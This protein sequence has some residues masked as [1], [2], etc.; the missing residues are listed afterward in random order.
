MPV[1]VIDQIED[2][3]INAH[4]ETMKVETKGLNLTEYQLYAMVSR[5]Y[6]CGD[7][8]AIKARNGKT[9]KEAI[10]SYWKE[11]DIQYNVKENSK[12]Y[13]HDLYKNYMSEPKEGSGLSLVN[14]RKSEWLLFLTG[15]FDKIDEYYVESN[16]YSIEGINLYNTDGT[17]NEAEISKLEN[18]L[19]IKVNTISGQYM[20]NGLQYKQCTWWAYSRASEYLGKAYPKQ[21]NGTSGNGKD[22]YD[23]NRKNGWFDYGSEPRANS[24]VCWNNPTAKGYGHVA[25]V[26][27]VDTVN[28]KIYISHAGGGV[29]WYGIRKLDW[30]GY[31]DSVYP[32][33]YI[34]LDSPKNFK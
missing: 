20:N 28:K 31:F 8:G 34:Y 3:L 27:A 14:R 1:E 32:I 25:Y 10:K 11:E 23:I 18:Q 30:N 12:M 5:A 17:V 15:Y 16:K 2:E 33:G 19:T 7:H 6:N 26:E 9:F 22:W 21:S 4:L 24:I 13:E 29:S